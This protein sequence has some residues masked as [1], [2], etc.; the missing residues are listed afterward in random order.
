[1]S[2]EVNDVV[3]AYDKSEVI[4]GISLRVESKNVVVLLGRNGAGKTTTFRSIMG[5][6]PPKSGSIKFKGLEIVGKKPYEIARLGIGYV[7]DDRRI[8]PDLTVEENLKIS[9][10]LGRKTRFGWT[11]QKIYELFPILKPLRHRKGGTLSGGEQKI[12][13]IS[14]ALVQ[15]PELLL[16]DEPVEGIMPSVAVS[17]IN[18]INL[19]KQSGT[20]VLIAEQNLAFCRRVA[21]KGYVIDRGLI[22]YEGTVEEIMNNKDIVSKHLAV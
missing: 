2:L 10:R 16:L 13:A 15:N 18:A 7:P 22:F 6:T 4:H 21:D 11:I 20:A 12:L 9:E 3:V 8:F 14:R 19:I 17:L 5:L 1:M